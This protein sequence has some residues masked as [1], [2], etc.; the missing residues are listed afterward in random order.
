[1]GDLF[2]KGDAL[3]GKDFVQPLESIIGI[4]SVRLDGYNVTAVG[5]STD[6]NGAAAAGGWGQGR[7]RVNGAAREREKDESG[8]ANE[9]YVALR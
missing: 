3:S 7:R 5:A 6:I 8:S 1:M 2:V 4:Y 9:H